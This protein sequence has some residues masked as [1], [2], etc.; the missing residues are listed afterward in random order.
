MKESI[1][2]EDDFSILYMGY[3]REKA[4]MLK[5]RYIEVFNIVYLTKCPFYTYLIE[6]LDIF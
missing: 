4:T 5:E 1:V 3:T 2:T 6:M